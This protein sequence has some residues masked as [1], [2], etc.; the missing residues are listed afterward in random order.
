MSS[1]DQGQ[2]YLPQGDT[3]VFIL[4]YGDLYAIGSGRGAA[5]ASGFR[6]GVQRRQAVSMRQNPRIEHPFLRIAKERIRPRRVEGV[7]GLVGLGRLAATTK[8]GTSGALG[9]SGRGWRLFEL[10]WPWRL[11]LYGQGIR[12]GQARRRA[13]GAAARE[14]PP[15]ESARPSPLAPK[16]L[17]SGLLQPSAPASLR[18]R[19]ETRLLLDA[20]RGML[21]YPATPPAHR[22]LIAKGRLTN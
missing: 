22:C 4:Q 9:A 6:F 2:R 16:P 21:L 15:C 20:P 3:R 14:P 18:N 5:A 8:E 7:H 10:R 1:P 19:C 12:A 11:S 13:G 17:D